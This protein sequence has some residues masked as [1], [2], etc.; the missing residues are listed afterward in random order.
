MLEVED[1]HWVCCEQKKR[2]KTIDFSIKISIFQT[3]ADWA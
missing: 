1:F 3:N 2:R